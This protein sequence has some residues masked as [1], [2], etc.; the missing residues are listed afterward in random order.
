MNG[1]DWLTR[2]DCDAK[3]SV[4]EENWEIRDHSPLNSRRSSDSP[5]NQNVQPVTGN[6]G[7]AA[8]VVVVDV[9]VVV[10]DDAVVVVVDGD[11]VVVVV[12]NGDEDEG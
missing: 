7:A 2:R 12:E 4:T 3:D 11:V 6:A 1:D 8:V 5:S 9:G 10:V